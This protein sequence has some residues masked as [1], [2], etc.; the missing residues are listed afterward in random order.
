MY[1]TL[2]LREISATIE[3][4]CRRIDEYPLERVAEI[5]CRDDE[6]RTRARAH[7]RFYRE[8]GY[9]L[10]YHELGKSGS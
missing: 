10:E 1:T 6:M 4:L 9:P 7:Y 8:R 3:R 5:V 2:D